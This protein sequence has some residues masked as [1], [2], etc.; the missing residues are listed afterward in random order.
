[1]A[2]RKAA[3]RH[4]GGTRAAARNGQRRHDGRPNARPRS[5]QRKKRPKAVRAA[6]QPS[7]RPK[8]A[9]PRRP[10]RGRRQSGTQATAA[11]HSA[12]EHAQPPRRRRRASIAPGGRSTKPM[13]TPPSSLNMDRHGSAARTG[14]A[15]MAENVCASTAAW[16]RT[17]P[18]ATSTS[19]RGRLLH[20]RRSARRR[21]P[22]ARSGHRRRHRQGAGRASTR[23]TRS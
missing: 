21:Q 9:K 3:R 22:H 16:H 12:A 10:K 15:E 2:K 11:A 23:T 20:R 17:S 5:A 14:R 13:P 7:G 1:M 4:E 8:A 19:T 6:K 18:A